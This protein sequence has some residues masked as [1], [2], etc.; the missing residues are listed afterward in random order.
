MEQRKAAPSPMTP[1]ER[2]AERERIRKL[3]EE[4]RLI[5]EK[6]KEVRD[7]YYERAILPNRS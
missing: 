7:S 2:K 6:R 4:R 5:E 3:A 1:E